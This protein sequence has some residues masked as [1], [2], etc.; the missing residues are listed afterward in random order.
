M[1]D[2]VNKAIT[3]KDFAAFDQAYT[4]VIN[5]CNACH[6]ASGY[7][8]IEIMKQDAPTDSHVNYTLKSDPADVPK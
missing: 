3:A 6:S 8:F 7:K 2:P 1:F 4:K 5:D